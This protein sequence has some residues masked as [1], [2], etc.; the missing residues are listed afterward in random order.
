MIV[1]IVA[2]T[3]AGRRARVNAGPEGEDGR[4]GAVGEL[5]PMLGGQA[6][7]R[8]GLADAQADR[9]GAQ[10]ESSLGADLERRVAVPRTE[11][12][13]GGGGQPE[14]RILE[15]GEVAAPDAPTFRG[16]HGGAAA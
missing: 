15:G 8:D 4:P 14:R 5:L 9:S 7:R 10:P 1:L 13:L 16:D 6:G 2:P 12:P 3:L 11:P